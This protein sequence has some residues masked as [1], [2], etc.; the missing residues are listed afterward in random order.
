MCEHIGTEVVEYLLPGPGHAPDLPV[1]GLPHQDV[2][3]KQN[4]ADDSKAMQIVMADKLVDSHADQ[5]GIRQAERCVQQ[6]QYHAC[7]CRAFIA[8]QVRSEPAGKVPVKF[9]RFVLV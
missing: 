2:Y 4:D 1:L 5:V 8:S 7:K 6:H 3:Y 9:L